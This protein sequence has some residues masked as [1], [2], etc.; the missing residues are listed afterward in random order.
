MV[1]IRVKRGNTQHY[2]HQHDDIPRPVHLGTDP[3]AARK[4]LVSLKAARVKH[5]RLNSQIDKLQVMLKK[6]AE[7]GM[8]AQE[9]LAEVKKTYYKKKLYDRMIS[10]GRPKNRTEQTAILATLAVCAI[11]FLMYLMDTPMITGSAVSSADISAESLLTMPLAGNILAF[12]V[13]IG[14]AGT[15]LHAKFHF[16]KRKHMLYKP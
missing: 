13:V 16:R 8:P 14:V 12:L 7:Q 3:R 4:K 9:K 15:L 10:E 2:I 1:N 5:D 11:I 6:T